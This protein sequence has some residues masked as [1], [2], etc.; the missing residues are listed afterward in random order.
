M[1]RGLR[2]LV[3]QP[4]GDYFTGVLTLR[5]LPSRCSEVM[6][7]TFAILREITIQLRSNDFSPTSSSVA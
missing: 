7:D 6:I 4:F 1:V 5:R 3:F 2:S